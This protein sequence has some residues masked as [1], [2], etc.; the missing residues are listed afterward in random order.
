[1]AAFTRR[2]QV[3]AALLGL[4]AAT[5]VGGCASV[6]DV[7]VPPSTSSMSEPGVTV[8]S[9]QAVVSFTFAGSGTTPATPA[10]L[11]QEL[12]ILKQRISA[13][14]LD[15]TTVAVARDGRGIEVRGP[16]ADK[17]EL[18]MLGRAGVLEF[19]PVLT[20]DAGSAA[21]AGSAPQGV[22]GAVWK[23]FTTLDCKNTQ[24][25]DA[26]PS[27]QI[28]ACQSDGSQKFVLDAAA[29]SGA[30]VSA[31]G[32]ASGPA[33]TW[34]VNVTLTGQGAAQFAQLT[35]RLA[36]TGSALAITVDG[37][38]YAAPMIQDPIT[39]GALLISGDFTQPTAQSLAA[40]LQSGT[41]PVPLSM[42]SIGTA[43]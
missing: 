26:K 15:G 33:G 40:V 21:T 19:R 18:L 25:T 39:G 2:T 6:G 22:S 24:P 11:N 12:A 8:S 5:A 36:G 32:A 10:T 43:D 27:A 35:T 41:L 17:A 7:S 37:I 14:K 9:G 13:E 1:M 31:A 28:A 42:T 23:Q 29:V 4:A 16:A 34:Q 3:V 20:T 30:A 38:V